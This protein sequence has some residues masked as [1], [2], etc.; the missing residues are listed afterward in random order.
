MNKGGR[1]GG[2]GGEAGGGR[3]GRGK[4]GG[5]SGRSGAQ[6]VRGVDDRWCVGVTGGCPEALSPA[7]THCGEEMKGKGKYILQDVVEKGYV[8]FLYLYRSERN[9]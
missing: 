8:Y 7:A 9:V 3:G 1:R 4:A 5:G 2:R 6:V